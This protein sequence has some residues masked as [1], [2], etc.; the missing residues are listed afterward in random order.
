MEKSHVTDLALDGE[1][2]VA[3]SGDILAVYDTTAVT[4][5]N[6]GSEFGFGVSVTRAFGSEIEPLY[7]LCGH[8]DRIFSLDFDDNRIVSSSPASGVRL[9]NFKPAMEEYDYMLAAD[10]AAAVTAALTAPQ[11]QGDDGDAASESTFP[12]PEEGEVPAAG[13][14]DGVALGGAAGGS[15]AAPNPGEFHVP[16]DTTDELAG[17]GAAAIAGD[18]PPRLPRVSSTVSFEQ[19]AASATTDRRS[20]GPLSGV[21]SMGASASGARRRRRRA[22][23][24]LS[25]SHGTHEKVGTTSD[26]FWYIWVLWI[27]YEAGAEYSHP[28][29]RRI[30]TVRKWV[31]ST[32][33]WLP[34][35]LPL[36]FLVVLSHRWPDLT[37][38]GPLSYW[39]LVLGLIVPWVVHSIP[40][41]QI[42][43]RWMGI[44]FSFLEFALV[45][46]TAIVLF[47]LCDD[48]LVMWQLFT[49]VAIGYSVGKGLL[50][51]T[52]TTLEPSRRYEMNTTLFYTP[53]IGMATGIA[54]SVEGIRSALLIIVSIVF[55]F[56]YDAT[57]GATGDNADSM[58]TL[59]AAS[60]LGVA[61]PFAA[62]LLCSAAGAGIFGL[63]SMLLDWHDLG[64][65]WD[66]YF[67]DTR[68]GYGSTYWRLFFFFVVGCVGISFIKF[69]RNGARFHKYRK[70][71]VRMSFWAYLVFLLGTLSRMYKHKVG[72]EPFFSQAWGLSTPP[73]W[74]FD[75]RGGV[76][77]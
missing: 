33:I 10:A 39:F 76:P 60:I 20:D 6:I 53:L 28:E 59:F 68:R 69:I 37:A 62:D 35:W 41:H 56:I 67:A 63:L 22:G 31:R 3:A 50:Y 45:F 25:S 75:P 1:R 42:I 26:M 58:V 9:W 61:F 8:E 72:G 66:T 24:G 64:A 38:R 70:P 73:G 47:E 55:S 4:L 30:Y 43:K 65:L 12:R 5:I 36:V 2:L 49:T 17:G 27:A 74:A 13:I 29:R 46:R 77:G 34:L 52:A 7:S 11:P 16:G 54:F 14:G 44:S 40:R 18:S 48:E 23:S 71:L 57:G 21:A 19:S 32:L 15:G 51:V